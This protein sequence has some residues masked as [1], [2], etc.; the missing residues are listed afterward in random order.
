MCS[1]D[2]RFG[3]VSRALHHE[4]LFDSSISLVCSQ[5]HPLA[6]R[7]TPRLEEI[8]SYKLVS[9]IVRNTSSKRMIDA[10]FMKAGKTPHNFI[11]AGNCQTACEF[12]EAGIGV[13]LVHSFCA[14]R[15]ASTNLHVRD[16]SHRLT[17]G[18]FSAIYHKAGS[19]PA[20]FQLLHDTLLLPSKLGRYAR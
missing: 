14:Q 13:G 10:A 1:S 5:D 2:L 15:L 6:R 17:S 16:L 3:K 12:V 7:R 9:P 11:E 4:P 18:T 8:A 19:R 20:I